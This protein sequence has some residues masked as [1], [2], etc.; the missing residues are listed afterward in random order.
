V[1][2]EENRNLEHLDLDWRII[3]KKKSYI[4]MIRVGY[5]L[6]IRNRML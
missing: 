4:M 5:L 6:R 2:T 3:L 1:K